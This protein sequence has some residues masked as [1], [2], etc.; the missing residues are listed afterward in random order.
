MANRPLATVERTS[1]HF[2]G[3][4]VVVCSSLF[5]RAR[6]KYFIKKY[7]F[8]L[9]WRGLNA[10]KRFQTAKTSADFSPNSPRTSGFTAQGPELQS[11]NQTHIWVPGKVAELRRK[12]P[13][14][15]N[16]FFLESAWAVFRDRHEKNGSW[17]AD[18]QLH[19]QDP[20]TLHEDAGSSLLFAFYTRAWTVK[21]VYQGV[22][23]CLQEE[24][25]VRK[26]SSVPEKKN[27]VFKKLWR[28][29]VCSVSVC[30]RVHVWFVS[31]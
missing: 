1:R 7:R 8:I 29:A 5:H 17:T 13:V 6:T 26:T 23:P 19:R 14:M 15:E 4:I 12:V 3:A 10:D 30:S 22:I 25:L 28:K 24:F 11:R 21:T 2:V 31:I 20:W 9:L 27:Y 18:L 16:P